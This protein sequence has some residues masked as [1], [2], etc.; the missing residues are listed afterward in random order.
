MFVTVFNK[1]NNVRIADHVEVAN[2]SLRRMVGLLGKDGLAPEEGLWIK[3]SSG[4]HTVGMSFSIDVVGLDKNLI[5]VKI[6]SNLA[7]YRL[8]SLNWSVRS[9]IEL[10]AG[11]IIK[12]DIRLADVV[13][14]TPHRVTQPNHA[15]LSL[16]K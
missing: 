8:T 4:V 15:E 2:T 14:L 9:V 3:P 5:V 1:T 6:W 12:R 16:R 13:A 10:P 11:T 7:P